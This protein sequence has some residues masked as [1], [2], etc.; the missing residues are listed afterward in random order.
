MP[1]KIRALL[2]VTVLA[3]MLTPSAQGKNAQP[4]KTHQKTQTGQ[5][6][7][8]GSWLVPPPP[9]F[10]PSILPELY[11]QKGNG[12]LAHKPKDRLKRYFY[13]REGY[14]DPKPVKT[15]RY[16]TYWN[17]NNSTPGVPKSNSVRSY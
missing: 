13:T 4:Q 12:K 2:I 6:R 15:N 3:A 8:S 16:V 11:Y 1:S 10:M 17:S 7:S 14:E 5:T 9:A